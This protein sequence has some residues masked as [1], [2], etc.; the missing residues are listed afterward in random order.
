[1]SE[2]T[3]EQQKSGWSPAR[4]AAHEKKLAETGG[5]EIAE[6]SAEAL[7]IERV[8]FIET[9]ATG[10]VSFDSSGFQC[11]PLGAA[12]H[13]RDGDAELTPDGVMFTLRRANGTKLFV[14]FANI[15]FIL[16]GKAKE[17]EETKA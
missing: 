11:T 17:P 4:R 7:P 14:P 5:G 6:T 15:K 12:P 10:R 2:S 9:I 13:S 16:F 8:G 3:S 1:M